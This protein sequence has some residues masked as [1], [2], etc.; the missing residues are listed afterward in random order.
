MLSET[1]IIR[2]VDSW[3]VTSSRKPSQQELTNIYIYQNED[4]ASVTDH[5]AVPLTAACSSFSFSKTRA[6]K[7]FKDL[8]LTRVLSPALQ[9][10]DHDAY[11]PY[12]YNCDSE[13]SKEIFLVVEI[14]MALP[15]ST[16]V[17]ESGF[18]V[19]GSILSDWRSSLPHDTISDLLHFS[20]RK[21]DNYNI[22]RKQQ[23]VK[24]AS[25]ILYPA[26]MAKFQEQDLANVE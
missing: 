7:Q 24:S 6:L 15:F 23:L 9:K 18:S 8:K 22:S 11:W 10:M 21:G 20:T 25:N 16:A 13:A 19:K 26:R 3:P 4:V 14:V 2:V 17:V 1:Q 5:F 12:V